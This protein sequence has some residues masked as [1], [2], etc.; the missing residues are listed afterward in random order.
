MDD[1]LGE[2]YDYWKSIK[3][4]SEMGMSGDPTISALNNDVSGLIAY[5]EI[6]VTGRTKASKTGEPL[7]NKFFLKTMASC[8]NIMADR[9]KEDSETN[10]IIVPRYIHVDNIPDGT[11]PF[12]TSGPDG[13]KL[14]EFSGLIPGAV[15]NLSAFSPSGFGRAFMMGNYPDCMQITLQ[16][17][18]NNNEE[19]SET[20]YVAV[21]DILN[22]VKSAN[23]VNGNPVTSDIDPCR[24]KDYTHPVTNVKKTKEVCEPEP[25][26]EF[27]S[28]RRSSESSSDSG[29]GSDSGSDSDSDSDSKT[30]KTDKTDKKREKKNKKKREKMEKKNK[31]K[32]EKREK[33]NKQNV[34]GPIPIASAGGAY[35]SMSITNDTMFDDVYHHIP[36]DTPTRI[37]YAAIMAIGLYLLYRLLEKKR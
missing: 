30:D 28:L 37:Y 5:V 19:G 36:D 33:K 4:P 14:S 7:G 6:L 25:V 15:G 13:A 21:S 23:M 24:F 10:P 35:D 9:T 29:S 31:K 16:T 17:V 20:Q 32:R 11:I 18:N 2:G 27:T 8:R 34:H 3:S 26:D 22:E 12:I 1:A